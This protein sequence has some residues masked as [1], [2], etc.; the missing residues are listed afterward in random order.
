MKLWKNCFLPKVHARLSLNL[1]SYCRPS[2]V[3]WSDACLKGMGGYD[4]FGNAWQYQLSEEDSIACQRQN[5]SIEFMAAVITAWVAIQ[6]GNVPT[7]A[8]FLALCDNSSSVGW[9]HKANVDDTKNLPL[10]MAARKYAKVL[11]QADCCLY[12]QYI[13]GVSNTVADILSR[14][15]DLP[16]P[17]LSVFIKSHYSKQVP[18]SFNISPL[19]QEICSWLLLWLQKFR[20]RWASQKEQMTRKNVHG[21]DGSNIQNVSDST[22]TFGS[23]NSP[24]NTAQP[25]WEHLQQHCK[26]ASF[27]NLIQQSWQQA[28]SKRPLQNWVR[29]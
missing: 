20:E 11:L 14:K 5:N 1:I 12:S 28:Q 8:C 22:K 3:S 2:M 16:H 6:S 23:D 21:A 13:A 17:E 27:L 18:L 25:S 9:L 26:D 24:L 4:S 15:F 7:E 10:H 19:P 29:F